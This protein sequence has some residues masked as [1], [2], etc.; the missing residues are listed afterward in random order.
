MVF[1]LLASQQTV[2]SGVQTNISISAAGT[3]GH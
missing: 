1:F 2:L 3:A